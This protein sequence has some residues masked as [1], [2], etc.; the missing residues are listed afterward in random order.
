MST[1]LLDDQ[2]W[3]IFEQALPVMA[4]FERSFGRKLSAD[5]VAELYVARELGLTLSDAANNPGY[6]ALDGT[7]KRYQVKRR[8]PATLNVDVNNFEFDYVVLVNLDRD[9]RLAGMWLMPMATAE[10]LFTLRERYR[11]Y[12]VTQTLFKRKAKQVR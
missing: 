2:R 10:H 7:G 11:K 1:T 8:D 12:Q 4:E 9:Y 6:D 3:R 5:F